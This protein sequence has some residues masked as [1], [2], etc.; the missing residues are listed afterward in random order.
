M[1]DLSENF[2]KSEFACKC[3]CGYGLE[4]GDVDPNLIVLLE[5]IRGEIGGPVRLTSGCRCEQHNKNEGGVTGSVH[6]MGQ[7]ADIQ[8]EGGRHRFMVQHAAHRHG[9][10]G[11]GTAKGFI[12]V[13]V[14]M[15][16]KKPRPSA[17]IY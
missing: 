11:V 4:D 12:H 17:W 3:G 6:C 10:E 7:A 14:H 5:S 8:V 13:D 15:G 1:G 2:S 16:D 9:A